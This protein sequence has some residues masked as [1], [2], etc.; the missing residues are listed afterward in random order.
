MQAIESDKHPYIRIPTNLLPAL[1]IPLSPVSWSATGSQVEIRHHESFKKT[2]RLPAVYQVLTNAATEN[3][4]VSLASPSLFFTPFVSSAFDPRRSLSLIL[5]YVRA[6]SQK[7]PSHSVALRRD[8]VEIPRA[9]KIG[10]AVS[11][12]ISRFQNVSE[13]ILF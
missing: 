8:L 10:K 2:N 9:R 1:F 13:I 4:W 12:K 11:M 3:G 5:T 6:V 7:R